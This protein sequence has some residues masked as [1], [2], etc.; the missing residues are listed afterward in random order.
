ML[1]ENRV[2]IQEVSSAVGY[3]DVA[4]FR[5]LSKRHTRKRR[6]RGESPSL[7]A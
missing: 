5:N 3:E 1:E 4:F 6:R 7:E 2:T